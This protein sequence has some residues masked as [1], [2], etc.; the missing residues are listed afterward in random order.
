MEKNKIF[1][2]GLDEP[3]VILDSRKGDKYILFHLQYKEYMWY[4]FIEPHERLLIPIIHTLRGY[5]I[6]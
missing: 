1:I 2:S 4:E 6:I 5:N 3:V